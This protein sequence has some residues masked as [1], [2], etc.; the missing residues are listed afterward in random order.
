LTSSPTSSDDVAA[1]CLGK[2]V[3][4]L[5]DSSDPRALLPKQAR[6]SKQPRGILKSSPHPNNLVGCAEEGKQRNAPRRHSLFHVDLPLDVVM[7]VRGALQPVGVG[8]LSSAIDTLEASL[9]NPANIAVEVRDQDDNCSPRMVGPRPVQPPPSPPQSSSSPL[10]KPRKVVRMGLRDVEEAYSVL[11]THCRRIVAAPTSDHADA[12]ATLRRG[13]PIIVKCLMR[14]LDNVLNQAAPSIASDGSEGD[15]VMTG[16]AATPGSTGK[17][18]KQGRSE[19]DLRRRR[20]EL[21]VGQ[22]AIKVLGIF[23]HNT[24]FHPIFDAR[25]LFSLFDMVVRIPT[26]PTLK[27]TGDREI[28]AFATWL[29]GAQALPAELVEASLHKVAAACQAVFAAPAKANDKTRRILIETL[30]AVEHLLAAYPVA[31]LPHFRLYLP[32]MLRFLVAAWPGLRAAAATSLGR[33]ALVAAGGPRSDDISRKAYD[34]CHI[35]LA[36]DALKP[37]VKRTHLTN[38]SDH[39]EQAHGH[40]ELHWAVTV[41]AGLPILS[42]DRFWKLEEGGP[43]TWMSQMQV[44]RHLLA[45]RGGASSR[46]QCMLYGPSTSR[47]IRQLARFAWNHLA[48]AWILTS[49]ACFNDRPNRTWALKEKQRELLFQIFTRDHDKRADK[50]ATLRTLVAILYALTGF[51]AAHPSIGSAPTDYTFLWSRI[52]KPFLTPLFAVTEAGYARSEA[53]ALLACLVGGTPTSQAPWN[54]DRLICKP[55]LVG[56]AIR[57]ADKLDVVVQACVDEAITPNEVPAF[58]SAW[59][60]AN[61]ADVLPVVVSALRSAALS[62]AEQLPVRIAAGVWRTGEG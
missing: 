39:L 48:Y 56:A 35:D 52:V 19:A 49:I 50:A 61:Q 46:A 41:V 10:A 53:W 37:G 27:S 51:L 38:L 6:R 22:A 21:E 59:L 12:L 43:R 54:A 26:L 7:S 11:A 14:E 4:L 2:R 23:A 8:M 24:L 1:T 60:L 16:P 62:E 31:F 17:R 20:V 40:N 45:V 44:R 28:I 9:A 33:L 5:H 15:V 42:T 57:H 34:H 32:Q 47:S 36:P 29:M 13:T 3:L 55:L 18:K 58:S 25:V 30:G